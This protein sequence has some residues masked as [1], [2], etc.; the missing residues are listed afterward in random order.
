MPKLTRGVFATLCPRE[1]SSEKQR[2]KLSR[3]RRIQARKTA[4]K[5]KRRSES[6]HGDDDI[7]HA[8]RQLTKE[9]RR[10]GAVRSDEP[11]HPSRGPVQTRPRSRVPHWSRS[12]WHVGGGRHGD[13]RRGG[14]R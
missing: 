8:Q 10:S 11:V 2:G 7:R 1:K 9:V 5:H 13:G 6:G 3:T 14:C 12:G 4:K